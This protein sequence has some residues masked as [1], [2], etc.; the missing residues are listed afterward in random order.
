MR[1][2]PNLLLSL[3]CFAACLQSNGMDKP[4][5]QQKATTAFN[6]VL[7]SIL[8]HGLNDYSDI[9]SLIKRGANSSVK[10]DGPFYLDGE[11]NHFLSKY[12][13]G[14]NGGKIDLL[15]PG[16]HAK[17]FRSKLIFPQHYHW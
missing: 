4:V 15:F 7:S 13:A 14:I 5:K 2:L 10:S 1:L 3:C 16:D 11:A 9:T 12:T 17:D 8:P 6:S